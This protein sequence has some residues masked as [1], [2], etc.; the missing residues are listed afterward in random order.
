ME[1]LLPPPPSLNADAKVLM[2]AFSFILKHLWIKSVFSIMNT[3]LV[4]LL[5]YRDFVFYY[6]I[7]LIFAA[8]YYY[9]RS[10]LTLVRSP[11][12]N[13]DNKSKLSATPPG[14]P[15]ALLE[16]ALL[17][18]ADSTNH[19]HRPPRGRSHLSRGAGATSGGKHQGYA[20]SDRTFFKIF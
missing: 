12:K 2:L 17:S 19:A 6:P 8:N 14:R 18:A 7:I 13:R 11:L 5:E 10:F 3:V 20:A 9:I 1:P 15:T 16:T 4:G